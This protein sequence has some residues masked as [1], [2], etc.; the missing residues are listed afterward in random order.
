MP[1]PDPST[2]PRYVALAKDCLAVAREALLVAGFLM[3][4]FLPERFNG[5]LERAGFTKG[6]LLGFEWEKAIKA[7]SDQ[8]RGAGDAISQVEGRLNDFVAQL[9]A[10]D[11]KTTDPN[12]KSA[13]ASISHDVQASLQETARADR[14]AKSSLLTQQQLIAQVAPASAS[15]TAAGW[16]YLGKTDGPDGKW[17]TGSPET[18]ETVP[19]SALKPGARVR[20]RDDVYLRADSASGQHNEGKVLSVLS[21]GQEVEILSVQYPSRPWGAAAWA[22]VKR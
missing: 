22:K 17:L 19:T 15:E 14:A 7:S 18:I 5:L 21:R 6:S 11:K 4:L 3:L 9:E 16:M 13:I 2:N 12:V 20:A 8:A 10:L 1:E